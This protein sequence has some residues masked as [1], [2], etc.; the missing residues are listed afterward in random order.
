MD[1]LTPKDF[2]LL[3]AL[4]LFILKEAWSLLSGST[5][6]LIEALN[7]N[8]Q[9]INEL[10]I[11]V[12]YLKKNEERTDKRFDKI[13]AAAKRAHDRITELEHD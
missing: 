2:G 11:H 7:H 6:K 1:Q 10:K 13:E 4:V 5:H 8:T 9:A 12:D 3:G